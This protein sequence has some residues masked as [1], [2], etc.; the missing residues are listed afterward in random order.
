MAGSTVRYDGHSSFRIIE[1]EGL[2]QPHAKVAQFA[3]SR[4]ERLIEF[5]L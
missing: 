5:F 2:Y 1:K 3:E 4:G